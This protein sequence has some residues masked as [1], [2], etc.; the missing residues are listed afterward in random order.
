MVLIEHSISSKFHSTVWPYFFKTFVDYNTI[1]RICSIHNNVIQ[2]LIKTEIL[3][4]SVTQE[5]IKHQTTQTLDN[6]PFV[7]VNLIIITTTLK[8]FK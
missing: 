5:K 4:Y 2:K 8:Y 3:I 6:L 7:L 1:H